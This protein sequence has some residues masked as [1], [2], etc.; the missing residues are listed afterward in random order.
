[1][2][3]CKKTVKKGDT[4]SLRGGSGVN[5]WAISAA[6]KYGLKNHLECENTCKVTRRHRWSKAGQ[7]TCADFKW[8]ADFEP[9]ADCIP[10][11]IKESQVLLH[12]VQALSL[13]FNSFQISSHSIM[14]CSALQSET[15]QHKCI[16]F[17]II[18]A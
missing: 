5:F 3:L 4:V 16:P 14:Q 9:S 8:S 12:L 10:A 6:S 15:P 18:F 13:L 7:S 1:M 17:Y 11:V 2:C